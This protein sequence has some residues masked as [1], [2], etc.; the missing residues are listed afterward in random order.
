M[1][2]NTIIC[3]F[4]HRSV[5][6]QRIEYNNNSFPVDV[7]VQRASIIKSLQRKP[8]I[9]Y[10]RYFWINKKNNDDY[11]VIIRRINEMHNIGYIAINARLETTKTTPTPPYHIR[12]KT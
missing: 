9:I 2:V 5:F 3:G 12:C 8:K 1:H 10:H 6:D 4:T 7:C 11:I